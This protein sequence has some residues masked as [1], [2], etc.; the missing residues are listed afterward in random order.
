MRAVRGLATNL[1]FLCVHLLCALGRVRA[2]MHAL[3]IIC[4]VARATSTYMHAHTFRGKEKR[5]KHACVRE[6]LFFVL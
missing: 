3:I 5:E 4:I 1:F 2:H 6:H